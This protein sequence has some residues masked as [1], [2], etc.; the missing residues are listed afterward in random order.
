MLVG[1]RVHGYECRLN[2][3]LGADEHELNETQW[4]VLVSGP[5]PGRYKEIPVPTQVSELMMIRPDG[6]LFPVTAETR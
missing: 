4:S 6:S 5:S 2:P 1:P 3:G